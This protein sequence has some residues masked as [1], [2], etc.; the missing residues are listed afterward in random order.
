V[1]GELKKYYFDQNEE[2]DCFEPCNVKADG[3]MIGS[4]TCQECEFC[5]PKDLHECRGVVRWIKCS[6]IDEARGL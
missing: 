4:T 3:T 5:E 6:K 2:G 1:G